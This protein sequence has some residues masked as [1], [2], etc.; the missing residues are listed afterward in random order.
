MRVVTLQ[1]AGCGGALDPDELIWC[2][3]CV[4]LCENCGATDHEAGPLDLVTGECVE[5]WNG[6]DELPERI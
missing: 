6:P 2:D 3:A 1:C 5:C 4:P